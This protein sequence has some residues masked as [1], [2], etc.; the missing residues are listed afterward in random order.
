MEYQKFDINGYVYKIKKD[1]FGMKLFLKTLKDEA[2]EKWP[3]HFLAS[4]SNKNLDR[5]DPAL[6]EGDRVKLSVVPWLAEG[7]SEKTNKAYAISEL[8]V[9]ECE[10]IEVAERRPDDDGDNDDNDIPF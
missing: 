9:V 5:V 4:V 8:R 3:Q 10:I 6:S 2:N 7:V 1:K